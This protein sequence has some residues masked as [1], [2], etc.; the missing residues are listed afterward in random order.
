MKE[1]PPIKKNFETLE[2]WKGQIDSAKRSLKDF[3]TTGDKVTELYRDSERQSRGDLESHYA[4]L[5]SNTETILPILFSERPNA[6]VTPQDTKSVPARRASLM[7]EDFLNY[8]IKKPETCDSIEAAV[9]DYLLS[10]MGSLRVRYKP[11][12]QEREV[13][14]GEVELEPMEIGESAEVE[15]ETEE[16]VA[17]EC[18][19]YDYIYWKDLIFPEC[20][21]WQDMPWI[22]FRGLY[23]LSQATEDFGSTIANSLEYTYRDSSAPKIQDIKTEDGFGLAEVW[24]IWYKAERKV[25]WYSESSSLQKPLLIEEDTLELDEFYPIAKPLLSTTTNETMIP[26]ALYV[27]YQDLANELNDVSTRIR[28]IVD[29]LRRRGVYDASFPTLQQ[30]AEA[31]DN[32]F[33]PLD[34][35]AKLQEKGG[36]KAVMDTEDTSGQIQ[37]LATLYEQ[38]K[39]IIQSIYEV[40]GYA[41][42][43]RGVS[44]PRETAS[45]QRIKGKFGTLR[46]SKMQREVQRL[47]RDSLRIAG[48]IIANRFEPKTIA[49]VTGVPID[50]VKRLQEILQQTE[51]ASVVI[52]IQT[53]ST[54]AAD[55]MADKQDMIEFSEAIS[56]F[57][58]QIPAMYQSLGLTATSELLLTMLSR[59]KVGR[60]VEQAV[61]D[62]I[63]ELVKQEAESKSQP[64]PPTPEEIQQQQQAQLLQLEQQKIVQQGQK[65]Q[66]EAQLKLME[67]QLKAQ[68]QEIE[69][70]KIGLEDQRKNT[71]LDFKGIE[72]AIKQMATVAETK[73]EGNDF[74]GV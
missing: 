25:I 70:A 38:R 54:V 72:L 46:V 11:Y 48:Q 65:N 23:T 17:Y 9:K 47:I 53:D 26:V 39:Q 49:L 45:A 31:K 13:E 29:N 63:A 69:R 16:I 6:E 24:E 74:V 60:G 21:R 10:G 32:V 66:A 20:R 50:D 18:I 44:D 4:I 15:T 3:H 33:I 27:Q 5:Y 52:D 61:N 8:D 56:A 73:S 36:L 7:M 34:Q 57:I 37:V 22:G 68:D 59:F 14:V 41:D 64:K 12:F 43:L 1:A 62:R 35:F 40:M 55:D 58:A 19:E 42:I 71:E 30:M 28:R 2:F 67:L 51:P